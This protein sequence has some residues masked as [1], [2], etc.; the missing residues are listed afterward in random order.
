M[1]TEKEIMEDDQNELKC[2]P[3]GFLT[4]TKAL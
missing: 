3:K 4:T 1:T 2:Q